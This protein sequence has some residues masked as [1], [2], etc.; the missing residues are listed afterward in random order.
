MKFLSRRNK[1][2]TQFLNNSNY[3][4][5]VIGIQYQ[6]FEIVISEMMENFGKTFYKFT[7]DIIK[8][9]G[10][11]PFKKGYMN[12]LIRKYILYFY[13]LFRQAEQVTALNYC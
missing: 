9:V 1:N 7:V 6:F 3:H 10:I 2:Y 4:F 11:W 13:F 5:Q 8:C 12:K